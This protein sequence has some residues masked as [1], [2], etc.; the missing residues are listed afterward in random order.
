MLTADQITKLRGA[1]DAAQR[2]GDCRYTFNNA[3]CCVIGQLGAL[4]G[5]SIK[6]LYTWEGNGNVAVLQR[7]NGVFSDYPIGVLVGLQSLWDSNK[8][9][10]EEDT[11]RDMHKLVDAAVVLED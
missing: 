3:P 5:V 11:R 6:T 4:E 7:N 10:S 9:R 8:S 1:I 2:L